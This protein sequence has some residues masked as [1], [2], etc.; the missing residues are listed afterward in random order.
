MCH[1]ARR[2]DTWASSSRL[3][4]SGWPDLTRWDTVAATSES[5]NSS[6]VAQCLCQDCSETMRREKLARSSAAGRALA[7]Q[8]RRRRLTSS[9]TS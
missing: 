3:S 2:W 8:D 6:G 7:T 5:R 9:W 4:Y 1:L